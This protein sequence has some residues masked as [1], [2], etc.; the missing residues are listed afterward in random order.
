MQQMRGG[1]GERSGGSSDVSSARQAIN[2]R[3]PT[4]AR[5]GYQITSLRD[6]N[7]NCVAWI[8]RDR[9]QWWEPALD[10]GYWPREVEE[11]DLE[12]GDLDE[13]LYVFS[14]L[15]FTTCEGDGLEAGVEKIAVFGS[16]NEFAHVAY[17]RP[18]G[19][20]SSKLGKLNDLRHGC[21]ASLSG[22]GGFEYDAVYLFMSRPREQHALAD[23]D[24]GLLLP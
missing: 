23:S 21:V 18:D 16:P 7:Y 15:G 4:L 10:G 12:D 20:W 2:D 22:P 17:Q 3:F 1:I 6:D 14:L 9:A 11:A 24:S 5:D 8:A 19:E 13:Y